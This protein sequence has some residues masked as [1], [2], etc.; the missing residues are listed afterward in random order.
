M[1]WSLKT[2]YRETPKL[3]IFYYYYEN[4]LRETRIK[5]DIVGIPERYIK[6]SKEDVTTLNNLNDINP[7]LAQEFFKQKVEECEQNN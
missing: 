1:H 3:V 5:K 7:E 6:I 4:A 2:F